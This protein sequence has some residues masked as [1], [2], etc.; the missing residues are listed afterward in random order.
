MQF[1]STI[2]LGSILVLLG[3]LGTVALVGFKLSTEIGKMSLK[4]DL[5]WEWFLREH[6]QQMP[7]ALIK[8]DKG[9]DS[10]ANGRFA[11]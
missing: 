9:D 11:T 2:D 7:H 10:S 4:L 6:E 3:S 1:S 8:R 5:I